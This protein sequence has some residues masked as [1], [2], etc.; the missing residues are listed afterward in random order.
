VDYRKVSHENRETEGEGDTGRPEVKQ[1]LKGNGGGGWVKGKADAGIGHREAA[2]GDF[3]E[4]R[5]HPTLSK[6]HWN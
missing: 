6:S 4:V 2:F 5:D 3:R 1:R